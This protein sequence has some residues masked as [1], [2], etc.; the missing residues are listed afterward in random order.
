VRDRDIPTRDLALVAHRVGSYRAWCHD[1]A[2]RSAP[3]A[4]PRH[5]DSWPG[6]GRPHAQRGDVY[7]GL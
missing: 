1:V 6:A 5:S 4:R 3:C 2:R 7:V